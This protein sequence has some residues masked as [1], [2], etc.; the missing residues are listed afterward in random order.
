MRV[1]LINDG[2]IFMVIDGF[3]KFSRVGIGCL[4]GVSYPKAEV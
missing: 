4:C 3:F 2:V 1:V